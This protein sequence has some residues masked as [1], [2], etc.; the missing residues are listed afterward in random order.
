MN[1]K[2]LKWCLLIGW[3]VIIFLL[4]TKS[5][6]SEVTG[7]V[8]EH[9][10][11]NISFISNNIELV[12]IIIRKL[13]HVTEYFI[14]T[15]IVINL[16]KLYF[17]DYKKIVLISVLCSLVYAASDE[18]HQYFVPGRTSLFG[19]VLIDFIGIGLAA[20][21]YMIYIKRKSIKKA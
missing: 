1:K 11:G 12:N 8:I 15:I 3:M 7:G 16:V 10:I 17:N 21:M 4:S 13:A 6:S 19:D 20:I 9:L 5:G 18:I 2:I 14:L